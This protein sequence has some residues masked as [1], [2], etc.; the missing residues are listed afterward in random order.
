VRWVSQLASLMV[1]VIPFL[2]PFVPAEA[3]AALREQVQ[4]QWFVQVETKPRMIPGRLG[5][6]IPGTHYTARDVDWALPDIG[7]IFGNI[8]FSK[9]LWL[10]PQD[11]PAINYMFWRENCGVVCCGEG[12]GILWIGPLGSRHWFLENIQK[13]FTFPCSEFDSMGGKI[14]KMTPGKRVLLH[15][16]YWTAA[17]ATGGAALKLVMFL[18]ASTLVAR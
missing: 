5:E 1:C 10:I 12:E 7:A 18:A 2:N 6:R 13:P 16:K 11:A 17:K 14:I 3:L 8:P 15:K 4:W 9:T